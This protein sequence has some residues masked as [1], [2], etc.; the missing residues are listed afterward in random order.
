MCGDAAGMHSWYELVACAPVLGKAYACCHILWCV[1]LVGVLRILSLSLQS[2]HDGR[3]ISVHD[4]VTRVTRDR[5]CCSSSDLVRKCAR[6]HAGGAPRPMQG[7]H[8][9]KQ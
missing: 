7:P 5:F 9:T 1:D 4:R 6:H 2:K 3:A 8:V